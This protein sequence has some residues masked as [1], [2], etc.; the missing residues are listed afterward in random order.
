MLKELNKLLK[1]TEPGYYYSTHQTLDFISV[2]PSGTKQLYYGRH[3]YGDIDQQ[4]KLTL[5]KPSRLKLCSLCGTYKNIK[6][7]IEY[8]ENND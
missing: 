4:G 3:K 8:L 1:N 2:N 7:R 5:I 6:K